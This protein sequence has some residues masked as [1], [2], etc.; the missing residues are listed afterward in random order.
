VTRDVEMMDVSI[1]EKSMPMRRL[2]LLE[3]NHMVGC[4]AI[5]LTILQVLRADPVP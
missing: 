1:V 4:V 3:V 5:E 2:A